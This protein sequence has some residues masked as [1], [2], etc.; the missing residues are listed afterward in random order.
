M[1]AAKPISQHK[2]AGTYRQDR[3]G[4]RAKVERKGRADLRVPSTLPAKWRPLWHKVIAT[5]E[6][7]WLES[8][9]GWQLAGLVTALGIQADAAAELASTGTVV[10]NASGH[11][12]RN[13]YFGIWRGATETIRTLSSK[14][15]LSPLDR[16]RLLAGLDIDDTGDA[17]E[18]FAE[19]MQAVQNARQTDAAP[20]IADEW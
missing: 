12:V 1:P 5:L 14:L 7:S 9:D 15:G 13:P 4:K 18:L 2:A 19:M 10:R 11:D 16:V 20:V 8:A 3:H 6:P 17:G